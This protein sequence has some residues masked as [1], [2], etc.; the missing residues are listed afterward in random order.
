MIKVIS[1]SK[2]PL[3]ELKSGVLQYSWKESKRQCALGK[4]AHLN[5]PE[6]SVGGSKEL[7]RKV[8]A[9][10]TAHES[11]HLLVFFHLCPHPLHFFWHLPLSPFIPLSPLSAFTLSRPNPFSNFCLHL[12]ITIFLAS[13]SNNL[14]KRKDL[15]QD[16]IVL[17]IILHNPWPYGHSIMPTGNKFLVR[18]KALVPDRKEGTWHFNSHGLQT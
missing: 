11:G 3:L 2:N 6:L 9:A 8:L 5:K 1:G 4:R 7:I 16:S 15:F 17:R 12:C 10:E 18:S 14:P 13:I